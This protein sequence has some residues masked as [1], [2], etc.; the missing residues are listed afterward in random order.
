MLRESYSV[1]ITYYTAPPTYGSPLIGLSQHLDT[2]VADQTVETQLE[3][4]EGKT[5][6]PTLT[7][8]LVGASVADSVCDSARDPAGAEN[9]RC[10]RE[11]KTGDKQGSDEAGLVLEVVAAT[12]VSKRLV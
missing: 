12:E 3:Q 7:S 1:P 9:A 2:R 10:D 4:P 11:S 8:L 6:K 5:D